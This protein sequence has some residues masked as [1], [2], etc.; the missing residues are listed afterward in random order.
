MNI[1]TLDNLATA[2]DPSLEAGVGCAHLI[3]GLCCPEAV[4]D[5]GSTAVTNLMGAIASFPASCDF[6]QPCGQAPCGTNGHGYQCDP[7]TR[8]C[9]MAP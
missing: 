4:D 8:R 3:E 6:L 2:C 1:S 7:S 9:V 5:P